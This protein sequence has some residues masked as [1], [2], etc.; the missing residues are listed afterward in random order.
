MA[1]KRQYKI[2][3]LINAIEGKED[4]LND[5][6]TNTHMP[7]ALKIP[8]FVN[9]QRFRL[10]D[11]Q[12]EGAARQWKYLALYDVETDDIQGVLDELKRRQGTPLMVGTDSIAPGGYMHLFEPIT[13]VMLAD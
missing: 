3:V 10:S 5:W 13:G 2:V 1:E 7:D 8:G 9:G 11:T 4:V 6:F 12:R